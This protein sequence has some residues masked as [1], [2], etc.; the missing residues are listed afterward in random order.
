MRLTST[1]VTAARPALVRFTLSKES[2]VGMTIRRGE[3][4][5]RST[6]AVV[7]RGRHAYDWD[8]PKA[9]G[10]YT[11]TLTAR[12]LAG[13]TARHTQDVTVTRRRS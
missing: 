3:R 12:D 9:T 4:I 1:K 5:V 6:S 8:V 2:R 11:V 7:P 13:N 10:E